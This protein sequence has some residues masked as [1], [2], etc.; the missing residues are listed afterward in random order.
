MPSARPCH[1]LAHQHDHAI[2]P[3]IST[4]MPSARPVP[5]RTP[6]SFPHTH[7]CTNAPPGGTHLPLKYGGKLGRLPSFLTKAEK[8]YVRKILREHIA[9]AT[10]PPASIPTTTQSSSSI[11]PFPSLKA[12]FPATFDHPKK[13]KC[14]DC[15]KLLE[16]SSCFPQDHAD[17]TSSVKRPVRCGACWD[18]HVRNEVMPLMAERQQKRQEQEQQKAKQRQEHEQQTPPQKKEE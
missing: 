6:P 2:S 8:Q 9:T 14:C 10:Q 15:P 1:Q 17:W 5:R 3:T 16:F 12:D 4:N 18:K 11:P 13:T 7:A